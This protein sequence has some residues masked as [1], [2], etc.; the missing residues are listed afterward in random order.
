MLLPQP[1]AEKVRQSLKG[2][3][4]DLSYWEQLILAPTE[5]GCQIADFVTCL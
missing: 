3:C 4:A 5:T 1:I 2:G